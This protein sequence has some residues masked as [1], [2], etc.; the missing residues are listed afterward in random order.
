MGE[1]MKKALALCCILLII[2][3]GCGVY[4]PESHF[5]TEKTVLSLMLPQTHYKDFLQKLIADFELEN[6][7]LQMEAQII[8]DNQWLDL[9]KR[10]IAVS[11]TPDIIRIDRGLLMDVGVDHFVEFDSS[12]AWYDR[13]IPEQLA[14][15][16]IGGRLYGLPI[17]SNTSVGIAY[18]KR[19]FNE[20]G[21]KI[22]K[23]MDE[24]LSICDYFKNDGKVIP[25]YASD[26]D[27][28]TA[29]I[30]FDAAAPQ[31][32]DGQIWEKIKNG[33]L[34]WSEVPE[35][36]EI[37]DAFAALRAQGYTNKD[38]LTS[39]YA[40][41]VEAMAREEVAMYVTG[42]FFLYDVSR[43]NSDAELAMFPVPYS[44]DLLTIIN[45]PGQLSVFSNSANIGEAKIFLE[46]FSRPENMDIFGAGWNNFPVFKDQKLELGDWQR[47]LYDEYI[48][49]GK[50]VMEVSNIMSGIDLNDF[51]IYQQEML[52]GLLTAQ[53]ALR[54]WDES[55]ARQMLEKG[56]W[57]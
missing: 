47:F 52:S 55:F 49:Q 40:S 27:A 15:K 22:P 32:V 38:Y 41:A 5:D 7:S 28:W 19:L 4:S 1:C 20:L 46:W 53:E 54:L 24:L 14:N 17:S 36:A 21:L 37:L 48:S 26:K 18:N 57:N 45:G 35:F 13:V 51:W 23:S 43:K 29:Q 2:F 8:P 25:L 3:S 34:H 30:S 50:T 56:D 44:G 42:Q 11:E 16:K 12:A 39:T 33:E 31:A 6:P 9:V 10:K